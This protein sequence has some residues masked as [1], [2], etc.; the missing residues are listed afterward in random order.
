MSE[1]DESRQRVDRP[2]KPGGTDEASSSETS[3][4]VHGGQENVELS[5]TGVGLGVGEP[6][7]F[8]PEEAGPAPDSQTT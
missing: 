4:A 8:E 3:A 1:P 6:N 2:D 5:D 7:T